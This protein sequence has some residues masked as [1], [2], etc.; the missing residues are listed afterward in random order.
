M[1]N[2]INAYSSMQN[3]FKDTQYAKSGD[4]G[5]NVKK[6]H[7]L[8]DN[9]AAVYEPKSNEAVFD[10]TKATSGVAGAKTQTVQ[11]SEKAQ[12]LLEELRSQYGDVDIFVADYSS[13]AEAQ[14]IMSH[15]T[16]E[17]SALIDPETLE[18]MANDEEV[19]KKYIGILD[20]AISSMADMKTQL[21]EE[22]DEDGNPLADSVAFIGCTIGEDGTVSF[23]T[24]L[25]KSTKKQYE[26]MEERIKNRREENEDFIQKVAISADSIENMISQIKAVDWNNVEKIPVGNLGGKIDYTA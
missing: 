17:Y 25:E 19:K 16:K 21:E 15:G 2:K 3:L 18:A 7:G 8:W 6:P 24:Q 20:N 14:E 5:N 12:A 23:F 10:G 1:D 22:V 11:L 13:D 9:K 4:A 26:D